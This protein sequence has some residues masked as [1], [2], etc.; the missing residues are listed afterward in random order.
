[1]IE[2]PC[3]LSYKDGFLLARGDEVTTIH[4]S[5][6]STLIVDSTMATVTGY[7]MCELMKEKINVVFCDEARTPIGITQ[8]CYGSHDSS[9]RVIEQSRW[10]DDRK[11]I[12][13][14]S[15]ISQKIRHQSSLL[16]LV[17]GQAAEMVSSFADQVVPGDL[18][19]REGHAAKVYFNRIYGS[20]FNR[21]LKSDRN[22]ALNYGYA[23]LL[24]VFSKEITARGYTTQLG[25]H[26]C[27]SFNPFNLASDLMEPWRMLVDRI[28]WA[29]G[30]IPFNKE[31]KLQLLSLLSENISYQ[32]Q[33]MITTTAIPRYVLNA[34]EY[35][36]A[37]QDWDESMVIHLE[38]ATN[39]SYCH[40]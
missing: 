27:N 16:G 35:L 10:P 34:T 32:G 1:V 8:P 18:T 7:L 21:S 40:V 19:N 25:I 39:E 26:H 3:R 4:L 31:Y 17:D 23:L 12:L 2:R 13:W 37:R 11:S 6:I 28:V 29:Q 14:Q 36:C 33:H 22:A 38:G 15:I 20:D 24:S 30:D 9:G 5:E